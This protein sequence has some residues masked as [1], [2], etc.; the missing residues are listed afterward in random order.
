MEIAVWKLQ[1]IS[2]AVTIDVTFVR[3]DE[4]GYKYVAV[5]RGAKSPLISMN[6]SEEQAMTTWNS[7][8]DKGYK[9]IS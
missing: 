9:Q 5:A 8:V 6:L 2:D 4:G 3:R 1:R 7:L